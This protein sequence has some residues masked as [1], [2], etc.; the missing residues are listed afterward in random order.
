MKRNRP[1]KNRP[2][3]CPPDTSPSDHEREQ[4]EDSDSSSP[5]ARKLLKHLLEKEVNRAIHD[6][7][8]ETTAMGRPKNHRAAS[9]IP[10]FD[11]D[12][13]DCTVKAWLKKIDQL[14]DIHQWSDTWSSA[15]V[16]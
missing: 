6:L 5:T 14:G 3:V 10:E 2:R 13:E 1:E 16:V 8:Q 7:D 4:D 9:L 15:Q 11:P 12:E